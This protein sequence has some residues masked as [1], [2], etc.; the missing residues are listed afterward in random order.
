MKKLNILTTFIVLLALAFTSACTKLDEPLYDQ[1][2]GELYPENADQVA[3][4]SVNTYKRLQ[5]MVD[6]NG[7]WYLAQEISSDEICAPTRGADWYD[8]GKWAEVH[9]H[10]WGNDTESVNR[11]W[12]LFWD[13]IT[14]SNQTLDMLRLLETNEAIKAKI[15]EVEVMRSFYYY[16][17]MDN[18]GDAP[19][20][21]TANVPADFQPEKVDRAI[22]F[23]S[24]T[25]TI[26]RNL[27]YLKTGDSKYLATQN[28]AH[29]LLAK[30]YINAE[31]YTGTPMWAKAGEYCDKVMEG[32]YSLANDVKSPFVTANENSSEVI[33]SIPY[34][35]NDFQ[36]FRLHMRTLHYQ[37]NLT[38]DMSVGPWNGFAVVPTHFDTYE[39]TDLRKEAHFIWG[40]QFASDGTEIIESI[41]G[42]PLNIDPYLPALSMTDGYTPEQIRTTGARFR[43]YEIKMGAKEN[44]SNDFPLFRLSDFYLMKAECE[45]RLGNSG[46][47]WVNPIRERAQVTPYSGCTLD[48]LLAERGREV[49]LEGHRRQDLI[50]FNKWQNSW[51][52]KA[53]HGA[54]KDVFPIPQW[55][56]DV[57]PNLGN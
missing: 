51:W 26:E 40:P 14:T 44:L 3:N 39:D 42:E 41:T 55:A 21:I 52:E 27:D 13:G 22:I 5:N 47:E 29:A 35:E 56:I 1:I 46:D 28:M 4:L 11:M 19:Y 53:A 48:E 34:D 16:L 12:S 20:L 54:E 2:P 10:T 43:K 18:Y 23:D 33:F 9:M 37:H 15:G 38:Y 45:I 57:N 32:P 7:W 50:R 25:N 24:L 49:F 36:G 6:D 30:L 17:L 31:V 8:G